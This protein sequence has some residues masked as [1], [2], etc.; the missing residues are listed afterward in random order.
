[1]KASIL[2]ILAC[3]LVM[4]TLRG[5]LHAQPM[6]RAAL[7]EEG[8]GTWCQ[9]CAYG[10]YTL[11]SMKRT[12]GDTLVVLSWHGPAGY[13]DPMW[14]AQ[15]DSVESEVRANAHP[16]LS[17]G[18]TWADRRLV[19]PLGYPN[20][21]DSSVRALARLKPAAGVGLQNIRFDASRRML[22]F[23][24]AIAPTDAVPLA[25]EDTVD[26]LLVAAITEDS[27]IASQ[28]QAASP[29]FPRA[30]ITDFRHDNVARTAIGSALGDPVTLGTLSPVTYPILKHYRIPLADEWSPA[31]CRIKVILFQRSHATQKTEYLNATQSSY[32]TLVAQPVDPITVTKP[33]EGDTLFIGRPTT[34]SFTVT[35]GVTA[36]RSLQY[37]SNNGADWTVFGSVNGATTYQWT[38]PNTPSTDAIVRVVDDN[39]L[40]GRS[41]VFTIVPSGT[42]TAITVT[43]AP[44]V[45]ANTNQLIQ[46]SVQGLVGNTVDLDISYDNQRT[47]YPIVAGYNTEGTNSFPWHTPSFAAEG[48]IIRANFSSGASGYTSPFN[49]VLADV[50]EG[51]QQD[52]GMS[53]PNPGRDHVSVPLGLVTSVYEVRVWDELGR[54]FELPVIAQSD[55]GVEIDT[56]A[57]PAGIYRIAN[58]ASIRFCI[59]R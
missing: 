12:M 33:T 58:G 53:Y 50:A 10:A 37:S 54:S 20:A 57:L 3:L 46:W 2:L 18:R 42:V 5:E 14:T 59:V 19:A 34:V 47:W 25:L 16:W 24:A 6:Q 31:H 30:T 32:I 49:I 38:V 29:G 39:G 11:D 41:G 13:P 28:E 51:W 45:P 7:A 52:S 23:D 36:N 26:Y 8:T 40:T 22:S 21:W 35:S 9:W 55:R 17:A 15:G 48:A 1:M 44:S 56:R 4:S 43:G 27:I